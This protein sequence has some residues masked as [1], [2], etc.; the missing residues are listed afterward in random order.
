VEEVTVGKLSAS[1]SSSFSSVEDELICFLLYHL[2]Y[3]SCRLNHAIAN[4]CCA[5]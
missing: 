4:G 3:E 5:I 2:P 1:S